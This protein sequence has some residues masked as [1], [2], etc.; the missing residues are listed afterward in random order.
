[1]MNRKKIYAGIGLALVLGVTLSGCAPKVTVTPDQALAEFSKARSTYAELMSYNPPETLTYHY[2]TLISQAESLKAKGDTGQAI[3]LA[4]QAGEQAAMSLQVWKEQ[5]AKIRVSLD[6]A[7]TDLQTLYPVNYPLIK[8]YWEDEA[9]YQKKEFQ[10]LPKEAD[11]LVKDISQTRNT[12]IVADRYIMVD[13]PDNYIK[14]WGNARIYQEVTSE[15][16]YKT[17]VDTVPNGTR[18]KF[19][20]ILLF[21]PEQ[22]IYFVESPS[23]EKQGWISEKY[24]NVGEIKY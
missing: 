9:R 16:K 5:I 24:L 2:R 22:T 4:E 18:V 21:S 7:R 20:R 14:Q 13:A 19:I 8:R 15:G 17:V 10:T 3:A 23:T 11:Q 6:Q 12:S 1:M